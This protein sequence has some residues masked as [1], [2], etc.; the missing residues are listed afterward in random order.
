MQERGQVGGTILQLPMCSAGKTFM[1]SV[2]GYGDLPPM[3][4]GFIREGLK[5]IAG[6]LFSLEEPPQPPPKKSLS[7]RDTIVMR[8][9]I[10]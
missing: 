6:G 3:T 7:P 5:K 10:S 1:V 2:S 4:D 9:S 8:G